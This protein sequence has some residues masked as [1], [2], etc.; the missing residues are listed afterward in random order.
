MASVYHSLNVSPRK[1]RCVSG[2]DE[3]VVSTPK[4]L[5]IAPPTPKS[6]ARLKAQLPKVEIPAH[7]KRL[8]KLQ[9]AV[10]Q[11]VS[12]ALATCAI[13][14]SSDSGRVLNV[15][16]HIT[17]KTYVGLGT[18]FDLDDL[19]RLC[20]IW[21]WDGAS[22]LDAG[23]N[24][25]KLDDDNPFLDNASVGEWTRGSLGFVLSLG[26][27]Y[28]K[29]DRK[30][31]PAYGVG[32]E[33]EID[34]DKDLAGGMAAVARW[35]A[36]GESRRLEFLRRIERWAE[37]HAAQPV[38]AVPLA[39]L[40]P[41]PAT[42]KPSALSRTLASQSPKSG[43]AT[44]KFPI[45][46]A[47]PS[48][49]PTKMAP[50]D[51]AV[52]FPLLPSSRSTS[53]T[54]PGRLLFPQTPSKRLQLKESAQHLEPQTPTSAASSS[55]GL[56]LP[57]TP[58]RHPESEGDVPPQTPTSTSR[59]QALYERVRQRSLSKSPTKSSSLA[60]I[61]GSFTRDEMMKLTQEEMRR[62]CILA[63]LSEVAESV[64]LL[65]SKSTSG[66]SSTPSSRKR[67][68]MPM[69]EVASTIIKSSPVPISVAEAWESLNMLVQ[70]CPFFL[71]K[72]I[73]SGKEW[74]EMPAYNVNTTS[75]NNNLMT[76]T[77]SK[78]ATLASPSKKSDSAQELLT[79]SPRT[80]KQESGGLREVRE[81]IRREMELQE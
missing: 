17:L 78:R 30:R 61:E 52:P 28:S 20:W 55:P 31:I 71:K 46:P 45:V 57:S 27:H 9:N 54:K 36:A 16:N 15:L 67:R 68:T 29:T 77:K 80:V 7:L 56:S 74:L 19:K 38:P 58:V 13:S 3:E 23:T 11:A 10:Q 39:D 73:I 4:K 70:L 41:L 18:S 79:R 37:I 44:Q 51:F 33:V 49:S 81:V 65:F 2:S 66:G 40:P 47:S 64:W 24:K 48:R 12:H 22:A 25:L 43:A 21:E 75:T 72:V 76:P 35:T 5:R 6:Q 60:R 69:S 59:R 26:S 62:R 1:K 50:K 34:I 14:P 53:P 8:L 42:T 63:R 32:I